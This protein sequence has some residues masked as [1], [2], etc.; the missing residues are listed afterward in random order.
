MLTKG[1]QYTS[2]IEVN[3]NNTALAMGSGDLAVF[4]TPSLVALME[5]AAMNAVSPHLPMETTTVGGY[6][7]TSHLSPS[8]VGS[9]ISATATLTEVK[10]QKLSFTIEAF[11]GDKLIGKASHIRFIVDKEKFI[12]SIKK[13]SIN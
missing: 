1:L 4:A 3:N 9:T 13:S 6:I 8:S 11:E 2:T 12:S 10:G 5:N 7:E